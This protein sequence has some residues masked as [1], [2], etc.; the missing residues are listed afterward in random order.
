MWGAGRALTHARHSHAGGGPHPWKF[1]GF[2]ALECTATCGLG[3]VACGTVSSAMIL[4]AIE[5]LS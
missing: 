3:W 1:W 2:D 5:A 4:G